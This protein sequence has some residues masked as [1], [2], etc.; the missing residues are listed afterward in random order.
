METK[1]IPHLFLKID[2]IHVIV[3]IFGKTV[4]SERLK[5]CLSG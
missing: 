1:G 2:E 4:C 3:I 5:I